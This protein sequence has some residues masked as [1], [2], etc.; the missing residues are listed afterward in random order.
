MKDLSIVKKVQKFDA[1]LCEKH[2]LYER[3]V[4]LYGLEQRFDVAIS[5]LFPSLSLLFTDEI[6]IK[7][8]SDLQKAEIEKIKSSLSI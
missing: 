7:R 6:T 5:K 4:N 1:E 3:I 8:F 2:P